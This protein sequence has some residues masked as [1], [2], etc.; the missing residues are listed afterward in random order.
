MK[1]VYISSIISKVGFV[2]PDKRD[3]IAYRYLHTNGRKSR[4]ALVIPSNVDFIAGRAT[5]KTSCRLFVGWNCLCCKVVRAGGAA[6][7]TLG[8]MDRVS[9]VRMGA[10]AVAPKVCRI[11]L[12]WVV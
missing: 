4:L 3:Y 10:S 8:L 5:K 1:F 9:G 12:T 6:A 11:T 7:K 2:P